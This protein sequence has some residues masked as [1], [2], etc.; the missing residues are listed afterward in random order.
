[1]LNAH[2]KTLIKGNPLSARFLSLR[3]CLSR[4]VLLEREDLDDDWKHSSAAI[5]KRSKHLLL[6]S[7]ALLLPIRYKIIKERIAR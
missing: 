2:A 3:G 6:V 5:I 1:M 7:I 4:R